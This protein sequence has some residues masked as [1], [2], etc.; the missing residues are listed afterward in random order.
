MKK[1]AVID[2]NGVVNNVILW[3]EASS[4]QPPEGH[5]IVKVEELFCD[6]GWK[7]ENGEFVK[8]PEEPTAEPAQ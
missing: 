4:W 7:Y 3:D 8:P 2:P 1:Y 6:I 5:S